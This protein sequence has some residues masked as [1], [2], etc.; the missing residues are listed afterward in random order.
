VDITIIIL[1]IIASFTAA[2][3]T[4]PAGFGLSTMLTPVVLMLMSPHEAIAVVAVVH[5][6]HNAG[7][8]W[9]LWKNIDFQAFKRYG[10]WL[11][12]GAVI[13]A[14]LQNQVPQKPLL[15]IIGVFLIIL[16]LLTLSKAWKNY[17]I[18][19]ENDRIGGFG[20]GFMGGLSGHQG[21]LRA[22][23]LTNKLPDKMAY[24]ATASIFAL[25]VDLSRIPVYL[26]FRSE[27]I[28]SN[29][30]LTFALVIAALIGVRVGKKWLESMKSESIRKGIMIGII[31]SGFFYLF[32]A[33]A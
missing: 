3:L 32:E 33:L 31:A 8:S 15:G 29:I 27:N 16:P 30:E 10:I 22:M 19:E 14:I 9:S 24:A 28:T 4:V 23:F 12:L 5:G 2:A 17:R 1:A 13:G 25:C 6:A 7:K 26:F 21:A 20:S 11:I 18:P